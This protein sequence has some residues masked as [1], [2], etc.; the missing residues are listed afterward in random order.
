MAALLLAIALAVPSRSAASSPVSA[1]QLATAASSAATAAVTT[2]APASATSATPPAKNGAPAPVASAVNAATTA[3]TAPVTTTSKPAAPATNL[4]KTADHHRHPRNQDRHHRRHPDAPRGDERTPDRLPGED[5]ARSDRAAGA[6]RLGADQHHSDRADAPNLYER[7]TG[8][9]GGP[10]AISADHRRRPADG[11]HDARDAPATGRHVGTA[12]AVDPLC[13]RSD[14]RRRVAATDQIPRGRPLYLEAARRSA[15]RPAGIP[16]RASRARR[17]RV[18]ALRQVARDRSDTRDGRRL[19]AGHSRAEFDTAASD[20]RR[21]RAG[22]GAADGRQRWWRVWRLL[23]RPRGPTWARRVGRTTLDLCGSNGQRAG[24]GLNRS[25]ACWR[26]LAETGAGLFQ[27][28]HTG[29][30]SPG[31]SSSK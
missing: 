28:A 17:K 14:R 13:G 16:P 31:A 30:L 27:S 18:V 4:V 19:C 5:G 2:K 15:P 21:P 9:F 11:R 24:P 26:G 23:L 7:A 20:G 8:A 6:H 1:T 22:S 3:A 25:C 12:R 10:D 29:S